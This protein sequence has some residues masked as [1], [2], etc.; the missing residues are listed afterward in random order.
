MR[1]G[2]SKLMAGALALAALVGVT[3]LTGQLIKDAGQP[4]LRGRANTLTRSAA[5][6]DAT[7]ATECSN[8]R[9]TRASAS[10]TPRVCC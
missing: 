8:S 3:T 10:K 6:G 1:L 9:R 7:A 2:P 5:A 4:R